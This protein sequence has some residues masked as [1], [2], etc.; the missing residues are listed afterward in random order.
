MSGSSESIELRQC[1]HLLWLSGT[2]MR[3]LVINSSAVKAQAAR[4]A[5]CWVRSASTLDAA[6]Q[7]TRSPTALGLKPRNTGLPQVRVSSASR[8]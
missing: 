7:S 8:E 2:N 5:S 1:K 4:A 3:V 6:A